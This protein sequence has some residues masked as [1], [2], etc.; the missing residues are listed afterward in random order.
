MMMQPPGLGLFD[1]SYIILF[2]FTIC[3]YVQ[4]YSSLTVLELISLEFSK[5]PLASFS[6]HSLK[7]QTFHV[8]NLSIF[9]LTYQYR[10]LVFNG[11]I[12]FQHMQSVHLHFRTHTTLEA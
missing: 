5:I 7:T 3:N 4:K 6:A 11:H 1:L 8:I 10:K 12:N 9:H 2:L